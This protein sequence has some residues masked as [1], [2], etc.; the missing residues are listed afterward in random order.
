MNNSRKHQLSA[1]EWQWFYWFIKAFKCSTAALIH[2]LYLITIYYYCQPQFGTSMHPLVDNQL[3]TQQDFV[4]VNRFQNLYLKTPTSLIH[5]YD[6]GVCSYVYSLTPTCVSLCVFMCIAYSLHLVWSFKLLHPKLY[7][8]INRIPR[9]EATLPLSSI[10][11][12]RII[13]F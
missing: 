5:V 11:C 13:L 8:I 10:H 3:L 6:R 7:E 12:V 4:G 1:R 2:P 9:T